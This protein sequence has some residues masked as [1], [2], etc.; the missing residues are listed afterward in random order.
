[1]TA[2]RI[3]F[4]LAASAL[5]MPCL[6]TVALAQ[7]G[8]HSGGGGGGM[9]A[10]SEGSAGGGIGGHS[11][12]GPA[13]SRASRPA[14]HSAAIPH[15]KNAASPASASSTA[16]ANASAAKPGVNLVPGVPTYRWQDPPSNAV[17]PAPARGA[18][19]AP[20][21]Q[22]VSATGAGSLQ[23]VRPLSVPGRYPIN[24]Q[25]GRGGCGSIY[26]PPGYYGGYGYGYGY[27]LG[28]GYG[29]GYGLYPGFGW[30]FGFGY[31][32]GYGYGYGYGTGYYG[33]GV[34]YSDARPAASGDAQ[35]SSAEYGPYATLDAKTDQPGT[36]PD[37][38]K[39]SA[40]VLKDGTVYTVTD[41]WMAD[42]KLHFVTAE[43]GESTVDIEQVDLQK[44]VDRNAG[45]GV[46]FTLRTQDG[47]GVTNAPAAQAAPA[48]GQ[49]SSTEQAPAQVPLPAPAGAPQQ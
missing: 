49:S 31:G 22:F 21:H 37:P 42:G 20:N 45:R 12:V 35:S 2:Y 33:N 4:R 14:S 44:T 7:H 5:L 28:Y 8:G 38:A 26:Y 32:L 11:G 25:C 41:Y 10:H 29:Y 17:Q 15:S 47:V 13:P 43:S 23:T 19:S 24:G 27:G 6:A 48:D 18:V 46:T 40:V 9:A 30:D 16:N 3:C 1:M 34:G 39:Q 36:L